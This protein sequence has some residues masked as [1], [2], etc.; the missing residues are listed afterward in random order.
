M[1]VFNCILFE[2]NL[3]NFC[4]DM[5]CSHPCVNFGD[6]CTKF[7]IVTTCLPFSLSVEYFFYKITVQGGKWITWRWATKTTLRKIHYY[8]NFVVLADK[9]AGKT[10]KVCNLCYQKQN[11]IWPFH[12]LL[13]NAVQSCSLLLLKQR[14]EVMK[15]FL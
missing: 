7:C 12:A 4:M 15:H 9:L 1:L 10:H 6:V 2:K 11:N 8:R 13:P 14:P 5:R 3:R